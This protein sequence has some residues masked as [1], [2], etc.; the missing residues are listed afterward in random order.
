MAS[1]AP[2]P[3]AKKAPAAKPAG[4]I[5]LAALMKSSQATASNIDKALVLLTDI[6]KRPAQV[7]AAVAADS[8]PTDNASARLDA[9]LSLLTGKTAQQLLQ[10]MLETGKPPTREQLLREAD[11]LITR[12]AA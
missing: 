7:I 8:T 10:D 12:G 6:H 11:R 3:K 1:R 4:Q 9:L 2:T 5:T